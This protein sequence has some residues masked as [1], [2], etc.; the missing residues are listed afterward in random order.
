[1]GFRLFKALNTNG[2]SRVD[3]KS[4][5][6]SRWVDSNDRVGVDDGLK[7][8]SHRI[9]IAVSRSIQALKTIDDFLESRRKLIISSIAR[10]PESVTANSGKV[11]KVKMSD[12]RGLRFVSQTN[13]S[14][15]V[16]INFQKIV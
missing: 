12:S 7:L 3:E 14:G 11:V 5:P 1:M 15:L 6:S 8:A 4:L 9:G 13:R 2:V 10:R 16:T